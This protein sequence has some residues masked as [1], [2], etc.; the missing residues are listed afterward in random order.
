[1]TNTSNY[2][3]EYHELKVAV[4]IFSATYFILL[5]EVKCS[6]L[7]RK[8]TPLYHVMEGSLT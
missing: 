6:Q 8:E 7:I 1:M 2:L 5:L 4:L 3:T